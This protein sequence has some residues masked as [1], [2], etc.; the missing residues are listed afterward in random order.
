MP[1]PNSAGFTLIELSIVLVIIGLIVGGVLVGRDLIHAAS[2]RSQVGQI[3][4]YNSAV[5]TFRAKY[6]AVPGDMIPAL[7][8]IYGFPQLN[9]TSGAQG[10][11]DGNGIIEDGDT[12]NLNNCAGGNNQNMFNGEIPTFWRHLSDANLVDGQFGT[13]GNAALRTATC[14][15]TGIV[16]NISQSIPAAK[17]GR[18]IFVTI[19]SGRGTNYYAL[20]AINKIDGSGFY[21]M[22]STGLSPIEGQNIDSK[23]DDGQPETGRVLALG[24]AAPASPAAGSPASLIGGSAPSASGSSA[25]NKCV[26]GTGAATT[27]T[28]N[29]VPS[30]GGNDPSCS[31]AIR[32]Q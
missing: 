6:N 28:Y 30:T 29:L 31:L 8:A 9:N 2:V 20:Y 13:T 23:I 4:K 17:I 14:Q 19:I 1:T 25:L 16:T 12:I 24:L 5:N 26:I 18:G 32:F 27:D 21:F 22:N 10:E 15:I 7:A 3:D 11:G